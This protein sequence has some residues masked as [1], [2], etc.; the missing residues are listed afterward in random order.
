M[1]RVNRAV[2]GSDEATDVI[3][4]RLE[5]VPGETCP[6]AAEV[7]VNAQR[8]RREGRRRP[9]RRG[10]PWGP[11]A[12]LALYLAH[13][14]DHLAGASD[15]TPAGR[16]AMRRREL[17]WVRAARRDGALGGGLFTQE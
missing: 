15:A 11:D 2:F 6:L 12:E 4:L 17:R 13:A 16:A 7:F 9:G 10:A 1:R 5:P 14:C 3:T 8:A